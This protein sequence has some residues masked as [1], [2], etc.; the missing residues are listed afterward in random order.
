[1]GKGNICAKFADG[2]ENVA[3]PL[4]KD[5]KRKTIIF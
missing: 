4:N 2:R 3:L 5:Y 1:M